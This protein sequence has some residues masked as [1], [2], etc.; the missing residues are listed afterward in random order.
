MKRLANVPAWSL[1]L[2]CIVLLASCAPG[3]NPGLGTTAAYVGEPAN[4][5]FGLWHGMI[6]TFTLIGSFFTPDVNVYEVHNNGFWYNFGFL[7]G[8]GSFVGGCGGCG[9]TIR[10]RYRG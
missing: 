5:W 1:L 3:P 6:S 7:I 9:V 2:L 10:N 8:V 4:F